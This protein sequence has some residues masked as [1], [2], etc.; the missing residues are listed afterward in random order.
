[1]KDNLNKSETSNI[2]SLNIMK[3][4]D[5]L[6]SRRAG[7]LCHP[8]SL[9]GPLSSGDFSH[10]AYRFIKF[11]EESKLS[12][13]QM[14]PL[15]PVHYDHSPYQCMSVHAGNPYL[16]S[17]DWLVDYKLLDKISDQEFLNI[18]SITES[19]KFRL[20]CL[21]KAYDNF[22]EIK[23]KKLTHAFN[24]FIKDNQSWLD[25]YSLYIC[26]RQNRHGAP[27]YQWPDSLRDRNMDAL[28]AESDKLQYE[29]LR[30]KFIQFT[31]FQQWQEIK[32]FANERNIYLFGDIPIFIA[33]DSADV[34]AN[35]QYFS[36]LS[37]GSLKT[38]AGVPPDYF[39]ETGQRWGNP[40]YNWKKLSSDKFVWWHER[41]A[42]QL[43]LFD[44]LR[45]DHFRG[46]EAYW[47]IKADAET[48]K[49][50]KW[51]TAP[52]K[53]FLNSVKSTFGTLPLVAEDLGIITDKV[54]KLREQFSI[55]G[56]KILHF[57]FD[58]DANNSYLPHQHEKN[59]VVYTG[60]HDNDTTLSWYMQLPDDIKNKMNNYYGYNIGPTM[61]WPLIRTALASRSNLAI[62]PMQDLLSLGENNR[63]NTPG[64]TEDN[65]LWRFNWEQVPNNLTEIL[66][67]LVSLFDRNC[68]T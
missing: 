9:P 33:H 35:R 8:T 11:L 41:I 62:I 7:V 64:T 56:M 30:E 27:W 63:M 14:L 12:V 17:L 22:I 19:D 20:S 61:P 43:K 52:G 57:A 26:I 36:V 53:R 5:I 25:N 60:T 39:S 66:S 10:Q 67:E 18:N 2:A 16:I 40:Q 34:W 59:S 13:W 29:I 38:V 6:A 55:P 24:I 21:H 32:K 3:N 50:G 58:G 44:L 51:V 28:K 65:W 31:F 4:I 54:I 46:F 1:M 48:A 15:G 45:I 47:E 42:T 68:N 37:D 49:N 23:N